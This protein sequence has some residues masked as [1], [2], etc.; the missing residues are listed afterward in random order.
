MSGFGDYPPAPTLSLETVNGV[1]FSVDASRA[2]ISD[3]TYSFGNDAIA[4]TT[5]IL[6][7]ASLILGPSDYISGLPTLTPITLNGLTFSVDATEAVI[8]GTTYPIGSAA[9][10][11]R[12][13]TVGGTQ[14]VRL[15]PGGVALPSITTI[16]PFSSSATG[17]RFE[18]FTGA[19]AACCHPGV[20]WGG[21]LTGLGLA[22]LVWL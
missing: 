8:S 22:V 7:G 14:V 2:I 15:G 3:T 6:R 12:T 10:S 5:L 11:T 1:S 20:L 13:V 16:A 19:A 21:L 17:G 4:T 18:G 9:D